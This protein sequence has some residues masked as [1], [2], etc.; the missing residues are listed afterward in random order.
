MTQAPVANKLAGDT[1]AV[2]VVTRHGH[3]C[4]V[5]EAARATARAAMFMDMVDSITITQSHN[6][7]L[8]GCGWVGLCTGEVTASRRMRAHMAPP[9]RTIARDQSAAGAIH[10]TERNHWTLLQR[11]VAGHT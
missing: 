4:F 6:H 11:L 7:T 10:G 9:S 5:A 8:T 1:G 2:Q 3:T